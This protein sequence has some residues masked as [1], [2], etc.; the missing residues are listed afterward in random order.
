MS[1][2]AK[3]RDGIRF[4]EFEFD[5][6]AGELRR[7]GSKLK[8]QDQPL[9]ILQILIRAPGEI[10]S[11]EELQHEIWTSDTFVDFDH[12][13]NNAIKRLREV[14]GDTAD[15]P[16]Y[17]ETLPRRGY[18]FIGKIELETPKFRSLAVLPLVNLSG[19]TEQ[20]YFADGMTEALITTLAKIGELR[21]VS[22]TSSMLYKG[23]RKAL[24]E[25]AHELE[26]DAI[27]EGTVLR[28][29]DRVR[30][31]AQLIDPSK[32]THL[33]AESYDR[34][35]RDILDLQSDV[36]RAVAHEVEVKL[37]PQEQAQL[38][39]AHPVDPEA[40]EAY[41]R[42]RFHW[43]KRTRE[44]HLQACQHFQQAIAKDP[45]CAPAY[46]GLAD[47]LAIMSLWGLFPPAEGC[48][49][50]RDLAQKA[51]D[52]DH[53]LPEAHTS[54]A[55]AVL[56]YDYDFATA[57]KEFE[58]AIEL[59]PRYANAHHWFGM[60][61]ALMGRYEEGYTELQRALRLDPNASYIHFGLAFV[62]WSGHRYHQAIESCHKALELD[63]NSAQALGWLGLSCTAVKAFEPAIVA[64]QKSAEISQRA[65][66]PVALLGEAYAAA[67][68]C[69]Q[70]Q[71]ILKELTGHRHVS[72]YFTSRIY[73]ALG[74][75]DAALAMLEAGYREHG[76]WIPLVKVDQRFDA[77]RSDLRFQKLM[78][79][80]SFHE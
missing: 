34:H 11:R 2:F 46:A 33:W 49:K 9:Q 5:V 38:A 48:G 55:W 68:N 45:A 21:V 17:I 18:R 1:I 31:T 53:S 20:E 24:R 79:C 59:N 75:T 61:L 23:V 80:M 19:D 3:M 8:L 70:A 77:L 13:I 39:Q 65:P 72:K 36:A 52:I 25:I 78:R 40:Y 42:G 41:L 56:H 7:N 62:H 22:R 73:A 6:A 4:G 50:A 37:T 43:I 12:G 28:A 63:P 16:R 66:A 10:V 64:L 74:Q 35:L 44:G 30:I 15:T 60:S 69:E 29:G 27:V 58:R 32:E 76:E 26:V 71:L 57:E 47:A 54:F 14:L 67:G 51:L